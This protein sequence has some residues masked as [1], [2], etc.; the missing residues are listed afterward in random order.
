[1]VGQQQTGSSMQQRTR[2]EAEEIVK[3]KHPQATGFNR[4]VLINHYQKVCEWACMNCSKTGTVI[5]VNGSIK[6]AD[7]MCRIIKR[8]KEAYAKAWKESCIPNLYEG[9]EL[10]KWRNTGRTPEEVA[11]N[12]D[13]FS[14]VE[15]YEKNVSQMIT[16]GYGLFITG[17]NGVGKTYIATAIASK[18]IANSKVVRYYTMATII[19]N[20]MRGW[21]DDEAAAIARGMRKSE[22]LII[23]DLDKVYKTANRIETALFDNI[24]RE[25]LQSK[26]SCIFTSN[27][28]IFDAKSDFSNHIASM[29]QEQCAEV[30]FVGE[31]YRSVR[32]VTL[33]KEILDGR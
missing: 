14:V 19:S 5:K 2:A 12:T 6:T 13:S 21:K 26:R 29:L 23:D 28:T 24:L 20:E 32:S 17:P 27:R 15:A 4:L 33:K 22:L 18:A 25:R 3:Q 9:S 31:D 30:V 1:M 7:C 8:K 10:K 16:K 11:V